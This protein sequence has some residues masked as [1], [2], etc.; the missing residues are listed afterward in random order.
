MKL[1]HLL[2]TDAIYT[3]VFVDSASCKLTD[4]CPV[5]KTIPSHYDVIVFFNVRTGEKLRF[6]KEDGIVEQEIKLLVI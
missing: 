6:E 3:F 2:G 1:K 5:Y 4:N